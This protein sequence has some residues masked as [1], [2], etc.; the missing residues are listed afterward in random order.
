MFKPERDNRPE[1]VTSSLTSMVQPI[2][3]LT[4]HQQVTFVGNP[5]QRMFNSGFC[6]RT[7]G[8]Y[9][10]CSHNMLC[11]LMGLFVPMLFDRRLTDSR[12]TVPLRHLVSHWPRVPTPTH[13]LE[14]TLYHRPY[15]RISLIL[16]SHIPF[17]A[18]NHLWL[19]F[20]SS[21]T[22]VSFTSWMRFPSLWDRINWFSPSHGYLPLGTTPTSSTPDLLLEDPTMGKNISGRRPLRSYIW[23]VRTKSII[24]N[25]LTRISRDTWDKPP[26]ER[27]FLAKL[28]ACLLTYAALSYFSK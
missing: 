26:E 21:Q 10:T 8:L 18:R 14:D 20:M 3:T 17:S 6:F 28:D 2:L 27:K 9:L 22:M 23:Y 19:T 7:L 1:L 12:Q 15:L 5:L 24:S 16:V 4:N 25:I 11:F 13:S